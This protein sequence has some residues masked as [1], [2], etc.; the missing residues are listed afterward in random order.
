MSDKGDPVLVALVSC[1]SEYA[2]IQSELEK[3]A[4]MLNAKLVYPEMDVA[5]LDTIGMEFG[6]EVAS[7]DLRLMMARAK[8]VVEGVAK[9]DG[10]FVT[11]CFRCA[12]AAIV[13][14]EL[15]RYI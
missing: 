14:N 1:G 4:S 8:A 13:R 2:G 12:E 9:V 7:P 5:T 15:R 10:V 3:A 6:L 11:S